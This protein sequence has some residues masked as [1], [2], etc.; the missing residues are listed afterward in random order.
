MSLKPLDST[1]H[2]M[3]EPFVGKLKLKLRQREKEKELN[4]LYGVNE[5]RTPSIEEVSKRDPLLQTVSIR[6]Q[7][8]QRSTSGIKSYQNTI[9]DWQ[10]DTQESFLPHHRVKSNPFGPKS[11]I[12][13]SQNTTVSLNATRKNRIYFKSNI[14]KIKA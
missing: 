10:N 9:S 6:D 14:G 8:A 3:K 2:L 13:M 4:T 7:I 12:L 5:F 11:N 1:E